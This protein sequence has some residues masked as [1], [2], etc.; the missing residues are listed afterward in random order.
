L[1]NEILNESEGD[2]YEIISR[3]GEFAEVQLRLS[4]EACWRAHGSKHPD[5]D[6]RFKYC[7]LDMKID[8]YGDEEL[9]LPS[10]VIRRP[11]VLPIG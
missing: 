10:R 3:P 5:F 2:G 8:L 7:R 11:I 4:D 9:T 6:N 1:K